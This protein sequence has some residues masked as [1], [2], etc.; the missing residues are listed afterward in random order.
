MSTATQSINLT[1]DGLA[2]VNRNAS[3]TKIVTVLIDGLRNLHRKF[4]GGHENQRH[5][6]R[7]IVIHFKQLQNWQ[8]ERCCFTGTGCGLTQKVFAVNHVGNGLA[9]NR[10]RFLVAK[11]RQGLKYLWT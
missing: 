2:T 8:R 5:G 10:R 3:G 7:S 9:L 11:A 1:S 4:A 6:R